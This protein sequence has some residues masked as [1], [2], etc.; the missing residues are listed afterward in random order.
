V[1]GFTFDA[2]GNL[3]VTTV[4]RNGIGVLTRDGDWH[5]VREDPREDVLAAFADKLAAGTATPEDMLA[6]AGPRLQFPTSVCFAGQDLRTVYVGSLA[7]PRL[8]TFRSPV[9]GLPMS[10]WR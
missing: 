6:T 5:V 8:P 1:D 10:H 7:M 9:P 4:V 2:E 3:W